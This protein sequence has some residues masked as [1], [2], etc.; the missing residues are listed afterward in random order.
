MRLGIVTCESC[1]H[2]APGEQALLP[3]LIDLGFQPEA[4]V[5]NDPKV[6]WTDYEGLLVRS[7]W[8][9]HLHA[10]AFAAWLKKL[11]ST[12]IPIWNSIPVL[13]WNS[14]KF[15]LRD[16]QQRGVEIIPTLFMQH[17]AQDVA[18]AVRQQGWDS[19]V[20]K[21][22][23]S[24][25]GYRTHVLLP[26]AMEASSVFQ[27]AA[28]H[29]D[30]LVQRFMA[31]VQHTGELSLIFFNHKYS[32][33]VLKRPR[34]GEFRVQKE[35]GGEDIPYTPGKS[36]IEAAEKIVSMVGH[37]ILYARVDGIMA[38][39]AFMLMELE[40][41]EPDLFLGSEAEGCRRFARALASMR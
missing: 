2:L 11:E 32:H 22:A 9:Y 15:Y 39:N 33:T 5:W 31:E 35:H 27:D 1:R 24:A 28:D 8:D 23:V 10:T 41:I 6:R 36:V 3:H 19:I 34:Q 20:V 30:F 4:V 37:P 12:N 14:H 17:H 29:G 13:R 40:L 25:S 26:D 16:L 38:G 21:P 18:S 7:V